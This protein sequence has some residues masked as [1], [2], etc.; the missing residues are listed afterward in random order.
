[1]PN[2]VMGCRKA[3]YASSLFRLMVLAA[4]KSLL[5]AGDLKAWNS[6]KIAD[7]TGFFYS[8][9]KAASSNVGLS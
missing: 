1:M 3:L 4:F 6:V 5:L 2:R 7:L 9:L 8:E